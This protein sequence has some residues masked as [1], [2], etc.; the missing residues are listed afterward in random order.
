[1]DSASSFY[2]K[3]LLFSSP[4]TDS[5]IFFTKNATKRSHSALKPRLNYSTIKNIYISIF[6]LFRR[7]GTFILLK[8]FIALFLL[9]NFCWTAQ[10]EALFHDF[11]SNI[12]AQQQ[13][14]A[15]NNDSP[16]DQI[17]STDLP[18]ET[19][20]IANPYT[21]TNGLYVE[22]DS[23]AVNW[24]KNNPNDQRAEKIDKK[25]ARIPTAKWFGN[26]N[27]AEVND[28]VTKAAQK[29]K[30]PTL[31]LYNI[32][33]RDCGQYSAGGAKT[34]EEYKQWIRDISKGIG[35]R[36]AVVVL[37]PDALIHLDCLS[38]KDRK[39]RFELLQDATQVLKQEAPSTWT[40]I[41]G[42]DG[43]WKSP[44]DMAGWLNQAGIKNTRGVSLNVSNYNKTTDVEKYGQTLLNNLKQKYN[45]TAHLV[46]DTSRNGNGSNGEWCN[47]AG[48]K[49][50]KTPSTTATE[51]T[52]AFLW[53]KR[54]GESDGDC[55]IGKGTQ[56]GQFSPELAISLINGK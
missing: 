6:C 38:D 37:E 10:L 16:T 45:T 54:P 51:I 52:D 44:E 2:G 30:L 9:S 26:W 35:N 53:I 46:I 21:K 19:E 28:Y 27:T 22:T 50:G 11:T 42:G 55:G 15:E 34:P 40:Y 41:D 23:P 5:G 12:P 7:G 43:K 1:L 18:K 48:R 17:D 29:N 14:Q 4:P 56:A 3:E 24:V 13:V 39:T 33:F 36:P 8:T 25:I 31:V 20:K 32:P 47:P 49:L